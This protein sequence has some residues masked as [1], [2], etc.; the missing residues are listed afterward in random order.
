MFHK[1]KFNRDISRWNT[2][3]VVNMNNMFSESEFN[4]EIEN[5]NIKNLR[6]LISIFDL[7]KF[8]KNLYNW[9]LQRQGLGRHIDVSLL[10]YDISRRWI[11][12]C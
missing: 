11:E 12:Y 5:W 8:N 6:E 9:T 3:N 4:E 1:S 2:G 10:R 7:S